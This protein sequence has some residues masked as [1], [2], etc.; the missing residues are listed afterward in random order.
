MIWYLKMGNLIATLD[1]LLT[2]IANSA[3]NYLFLIKIHFAGSLYE[4]IKT[5]RIIKLIKLEDNIMTHKITMK[6]HCGYHFKDVEVNDTF[7]CPQC[8]LKLFFKYNP[9]ISTY[10]LEIIE[11]VR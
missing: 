9:K 3:R 10:E 7:T 4:N 5:G 1:V 11:D 6:C 8:G 2:N